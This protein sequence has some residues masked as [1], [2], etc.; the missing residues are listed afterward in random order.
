MGRRLALI[1]VAAVTPLLGACSP[2]GELQVTVIGRGAIHIMLVASGS[3]RGGCLGM[4]FIQRT[5]G[6]G[7][8]MVDGPPAIEFGRGGDSSGRCRKEMT[9]DGSGGIALVSGR[10]PLAPGNYRVFSDYGIGRAH[11][12]FTI[13]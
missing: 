5:Q 7:G 3:A 13:S 10:F 2:G 6:P 8:Q 1:A 11:G 12:E 9:I 4:G